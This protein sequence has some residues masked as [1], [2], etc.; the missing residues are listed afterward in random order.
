M[1]RQFAKMGSKKYDLLIIGGGITGACVAHDAVLRGLSVALVEMRDF[2]WATSAATSKLIHGGLRYLKNMEFGLV[3]ESLR[4]RRTLEIIAPHLVYP[5]P[6]L[7][8]TY[9]ESSNSRLVIFPGMILYDILSYDKGKV[10]DPGRKVPHFELLT[11]KQVLEREPTTNSKDLTGGAIYYDCQMYSPERLTL[12]FVLSAAKNGADIANY[13][14]V[15]QL[16]LDDG[17]VKGARVKDILTNNI[18][19]I[20]A[21]IT[22][23]VSGPWADYIAGLALSETKTKVVRSEGIHLITSPIVKSHA[24]VYRTSTG[25]HFFIIPWRG[26]SLIGT[27]DTRY[28]GSPDDYGVSEE[29]VKAFLDE[30]NET[31]TS[32]NLSLENIDYT[33]GGLRPIVEEETE[34]EIDVYD[35]SRKYEIF[36]HE[37]EDKLKGFVTVIGG[38]YTTSRSLAKELVD[39]VI[40]KLNLPK[41]ECITDVVPVV[42]GNIR[43]WEGVL[44]EAKIRYENIPEKVLMNLLHSYGSR[45]EQVLDLVNEDESLGERISEGADAIKAQIV[46]GARHE[47]AMSLEDIV[48]RRTNVLLVSKLSPEGILSIAEIFGKEMNWG[49]EEI[50]TQADNIWKVYSNK[51][52]RQKNRP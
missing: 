30:I 1:E 2:G 35:K 50:K 19:D 52:I 34:V 43:N 26:K 21:S 51:N 3:R 39:Q 9:K 32:A 20:E 45:Y 37:K 22:V 17:K 42:G 11:R 18:I 44:A 41:K 5:F 31:H 6:F 10:E 25:R 49:R 29:N 15:E 24:L 36:D 27:T 4:E 47:L 13:A 12:S 33:Y 48:N 14:K 16:N 46:F 7:I 38:K 8:P 40:E 23:N 28:D